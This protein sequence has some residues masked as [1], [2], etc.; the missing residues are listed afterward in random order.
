MNGGDFEQ[1]AV[2]GSRAPALEVEGLHKSY[3]I[4]DKPFDALLDAFRRT[5]HSREHVVLSDVSF[6]LPK[7]E[8]MGVIGPNGAGK[9]TL[10]KI[11]AGTLSAS[12]GSV[13]IDG[14]ISAI[15]ELGT[16]FHPDYTGYDNIMLGGLA[17]GMSRD[18]VL[19]S[20]DEVI[21]FSELGSAI[22]QPFRTYSSGMQARLTFSTAINVKPDILIIDEA[23]AAGDAY[24]VHKCLG[25]IRAICES[26]ASVLFVSHS[27][28]IVAEL[29]DRAMWID[30]GTIRTIGPAE[31]VAKMYSQSVWARTGD[32]LAVDNAKTSEELEALGYELGG[33]EI[34]ITG[35]RLEDDNGALLTAVNSRQS[36]TVVLTWQGEFSSG[37]VTPSFRIDSHDRQAVTG[38]EG[39]KHEEFIKVTEESEGFGTVRL[40]V[41]RLEL[42]SGT[43]FISVSL[44]R[45]MIPRDKEAI[46]HYIEKAFRFFVPQANVWPS[47]FS[48][49]PEVEVTYE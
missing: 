25:R 14:K 28:G 39:Y 5:P 35:V 48:Y 42:G 9:S 23:L 8:V 2:Q 6:T 22:Y 3:R 17:Q 43:Y 11:I 20:R 12:K 19:S 27:E 30:S 26:G 15:L 4:H 44:S 1:L 40:R 31:A 18:E 32:Q 45:K 13:T 16:G 47:G 46:L 34:R 10:L 41:P 7:G 36:A 38:Y 37:E 33:R 24:F 29:C 49:E 21:A